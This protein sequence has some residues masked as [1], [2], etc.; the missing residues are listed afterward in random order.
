VTTEPEPTKPATLMDVFLEGAHGA[1]DVN[2]VGCLWDIFNDVREKL[3]RILEYN[4]LTNSRIREIDDELGAY[5]DANF[6]QED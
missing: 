3:T 4:G 6:T 2:M 1:A 5:L